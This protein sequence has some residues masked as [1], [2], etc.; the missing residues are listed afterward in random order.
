MLEVY[1]FRVLQSYKYPKDY[2]SVVAL[3]DKPARSTYSYSNLGTESTTK[4]MVAITKF[5]NYYDID[6]WIPSWFYYFF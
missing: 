2:S 3:Y 6:N 5:Q 1:G 4:H